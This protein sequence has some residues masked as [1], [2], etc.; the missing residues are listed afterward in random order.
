MSEDEV[1]KQVRRRTGGRSARVRSAVLQATL[2]VVAEQGPAAVT[3]GDIARRAGV[4]ASSIQRR[5]G[6]PENLTLDALL[7]YSQAQL[8]VPDT[9]T[10][11]GDLI[12]FARLIVAY[13]ATP[14]GAALVRAMAVADDDPALADSRARFW[15]S[16]LDASRPIID[17][18]AARGE[19][20]TGTDPQL[21]LE[22]LVS[23]LHM[24][25][26]L[27]RQPLDDAWIER[28]VDTALNGVAQV[29]PSATSRPGTRASVH[30]GTTPSSSNS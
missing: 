11:R 29:S 30:Q 25:A 21:P 7:A 3:M 20:A 14:L 19:L 26:L 15:R 1:E 13:L 8:P 24:R 12:E 9:G 10:V 4:H 27:T 28:I 17:R 18:A 2:D 23:S 22:L 6:S 5:W 16:R